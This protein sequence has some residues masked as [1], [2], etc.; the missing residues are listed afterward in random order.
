MRQNVRKDLQHVGLLMTLPL[1][2]LTSPLQSLYQQ[3]GKFVHQLHISKISTIL[4][5]PTKRLV[6]I[7][8]RENEE[9]APYRLSGPSVS[10][11]PA[12]TRTHSLSHLF[13]VVLFFT[14]IVMARCAL[15]KV[16]AIVPLA[17]IVRAQETSS[18]TEVEFGK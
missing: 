1:T 16:A 5:R 12:Y 4:R 7:H 15:M 18:T 6:R 3:A 8:T 13:T 14:A 9:R 11:F 2:M 17:L 10:D